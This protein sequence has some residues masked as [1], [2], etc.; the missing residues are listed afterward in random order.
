MLL[1]R[2]RWF[3]N[4]WRVLCCALPCGYSCGVMESSVVLFRLRVVIVFRGNI[5]VIIILYS[6]HLVIYEHF[7]SVC[8]EQLILGHTYD[9][10]L[11]LAWKP[12]I[13]ESPVS[14][15]VGKGSG[16]SIVFGSG[17]KV[18]SG[19]GPIPTS[20]AECPVD[21]AHS[22]SGISQFPFKLFQI[23]FKYSLNF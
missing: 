4:L 14:H 10:Y 7:W 22:N 23:H 11:V 2:K 8:M 20:W 16:E 12:G 3:G 6:W 19:L 17:L 13:S 18:S 5:Y 1:R 9:E 21:R 15:R